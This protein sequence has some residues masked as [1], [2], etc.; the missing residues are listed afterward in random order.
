MKRIFIFLITF[1][2]LL[3]FFVPVFAFADDDKAYTEVYDIL[4]DNVKD[5]F[6][7]NGIESLPDLIEKIQNDGIGIIFDIALNNI[8]L[9]FSSM[10]MVMAVSIFG[11]VINIFIE[12]NELKK[13]TDI[14]FTL[15]ICVLLI[16][17]FK[18]ILIKTADCINSCGVFLYSFLPIFAAFM[19]LSKNTTGSVLYTSSIY[20]FNQLFMYLSDNIIVPFS[21]GYFGLSLSSI[22]A[23]NILMDLLN[24]LK[25]TAIWCLTLITTVFA[26][27]TSV[28]T[29]VASAADSVVMKTGK[30]IFGTS[31]PVVGGY[32]S[33]VLNT[34]IGGISVMRSGL[35]F[36]VIVVIFILF[37]PLLAE[38]LFWKLAVKLCSFIHS[39]DNSSALINAFNDV[40]TMLLS[41]LVCLFIGMIL[42]ISAMLV[43]GGLK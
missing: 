8:R 10:F 29:V 24:S 42:S 16:A 9:P 4:P 2:L 12:R 15:I 39:S 36:F 37:V 19:T 41:V 43:L 27:M 6:E 32:V 3:L 13:I 25:K 20:L 34:V 35:G 5:S 14:I 26:A 23:D 22:I 31:I 30:F 17:P 7:D 1:L 33:E 11:A 40:L 21:V 38:L 28:Q 18:D